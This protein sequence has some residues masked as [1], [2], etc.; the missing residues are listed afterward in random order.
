MAREVL[1]MAKVPPH[2]PVKEGPQPSPKPPHKHIKEG[3][4]P[5]PKQAY[6]LS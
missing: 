1:A 6:K 4:Q 5:S 3:F 2:E